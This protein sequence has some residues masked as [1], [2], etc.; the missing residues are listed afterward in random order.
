MTAIKLCNT[1]EYGTHF[2]ITLRY[3][4]EVTA[5]SKLM[6]RKGE[7]KIIPPV[8]L[9]KKVKLRKRKAPIDVIRQK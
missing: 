4:L 9:N 8:K 1:F 2:P 5:F 7:T 6:L 3:I